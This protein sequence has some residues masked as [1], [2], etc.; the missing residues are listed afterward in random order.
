MVPINALVVVGDGQRAHVLLSSGELV[1]SIDLSAI[2]PGVIERVGRAGD[3]VVMQGGG[4]LI[5]SDAE[6]STFHVW[7]NS[8]KSEIDW[9]A[10]VQP[11]AKGLEAIESAWRGPGVTVERVLLDLHS[12][13]ILSRTGTLLMDIV[14]VL[15]IVLSISGLIM[16]NVRNRRR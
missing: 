16:S 7:D 3:S 15:L 4:R 8:F 1:E 10:E 5:R 9:S 11:D 13:R 12:G 2:L 14:A 6:V